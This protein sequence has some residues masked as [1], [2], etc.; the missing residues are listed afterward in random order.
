MAKT[1]NEQIEALQDE[2]LRLKFL[3]KLFEKAVKNEFDMNVK[4]IHKLIENSK[5]R[6]IL[7]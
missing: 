7:R 4:T 5:K 6:M 1:L 3:E 2:N